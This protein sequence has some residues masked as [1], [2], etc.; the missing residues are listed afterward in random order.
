MAYVKIKNKESGA[1]KEIIQLAQETP[2][3]DLGELFE[4]EVVEMLYK[5]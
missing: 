3:A 2:I 5:N 4:A 1:I